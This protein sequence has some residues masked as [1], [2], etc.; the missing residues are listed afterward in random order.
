MSSH[1]HPEN[2]PPAG[3]PDGTTCRPLRGAYVLIM[4]HQTTRRAI[5]RAIT[6]ASRTAAYEAARAE[7]VSRGKW[8]IARFLALR[9]EKCREDARRE[10][11]KIGK[12][13]SNQP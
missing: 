10:L 7:A 11:A 2:G 13:P 8:L 4:D 6:L 1:R 3:F 5:S 9:I 12:Q